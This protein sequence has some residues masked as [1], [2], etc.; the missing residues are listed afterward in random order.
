MRSSAKTSQGNPGSHYVEQGLLAYAAGFERPV[1]LQL[2]RQPAHEGRVQGAGNAPG[3]AGA[4]LRA[5]WAYPMVEDPDG[6]PTPVRASAPVRLLVHAPPAAWG[7]RAAQAEPPPRTGVV[8][9]PTV[10]EVKESSRYERL[11]IY[12]EPDNAVIWFGSQSFKGVGQ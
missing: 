7:W 1:G 6:Q 2:T 10:G 3:S 9:V 12:S 4:S 5:L 11:Y 8:P